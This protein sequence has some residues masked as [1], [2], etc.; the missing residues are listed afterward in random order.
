MNKK[1][2]PLLLIVEDEEDHQDILKAFLEKNYDL[3]Q[4]TTNKEALNLFREHYETIDVILL[5]MHLPDGNA[6]DLFKKLESIIFTGMPNIIMVTAQGKPTDIA[7]TISELGAFD[8]ISKPYDM[9]ELFTSIKKAL[10]QPT[11]PRRAYELS[12]DM[13]LDQLI[14]DR[15][16]LIFNELND[17][18]YA[19]GRPLSSEDLDPFIYYAKET[20]KK[21]KPLTEI[22]A[23]FELD[24][25]SKAPKPSPA[26]ILIVE[27]EDQI[28]DDLEEL[29]TSTSYTIKTAKTATIALD[30][31]KTSPN[32]DIILLD[33]GLPDMEG[34]A[35]ID[36]VK[37]EISHIKNDPS[38]A[39][40]ITDHSAP[41]IIVMSSY[42]DKEHIKKTLQAGASYYLTKPLEYKHLLE[43]IS[44]ILFKRHCLN[45]LPLLLEELKTQRASFRIRFQLLNELVKA[46]GSETMA[47]SDVYKYFDEYECDEF[48]RELVLEK[49][50]DDELVLFL[51]ELKATTT[52]VTD[53]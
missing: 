5:D 7:K 48:P 25:G 23:D 18:R 30:I 47:L 31:I 29:F 52:P 9:N 8:H 24:T 42:S 15:N 12:K 26:T 33:I 16:L 22:L 4:A 41:D 44:T 36:E 3:L 17:L 19:Q 51:I 35:I 32:I 11:F 21:N 2:R 14:S 10:N 6:F 39:W 53:L 13:Y 20:T 27:D 45:V 49:K 38:A 46:S 37:K 34:T 40:D 43:L 28:R 50:V 1:E